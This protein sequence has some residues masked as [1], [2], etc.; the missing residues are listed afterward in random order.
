M[1]DVFVHIYSFPSYTAADV[2]NRKRYFGKS[3]CNSCCYLD[4]NLAVKI[5][6]HVDC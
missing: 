3:L 6:I 1:V 2:H 5:Q 4:D